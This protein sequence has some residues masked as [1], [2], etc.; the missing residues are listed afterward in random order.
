MAAFAD[1]QTAEVH[2]LFVQFDCT[3]ATQ[4]FGGAHVDALD[5]LGAMQ[6]APLQYVTFETQLF[7]RLH[8]S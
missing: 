3:H 2:A 7:D 1:R 5:A 4:A 8:V 6:L